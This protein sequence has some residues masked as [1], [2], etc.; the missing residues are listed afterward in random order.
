MA[1]VSSKE[2]LILSAKFRA[3]PVMALLEMTQKISGEYMQKMDELKSV[4]E[5]KTKKKERNH[6]NLFNL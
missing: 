6:E 4:Y 1:K 5:D 3:N 2:Y